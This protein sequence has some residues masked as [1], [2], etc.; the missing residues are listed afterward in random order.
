MT[1]LLVICGFIISIN[2]AL[3][4]LFKF[5]F[6]NH[7][8][9]S[10]AFEWP[11]VS[12]LVAARNEERHLRNCVQALLELDYPKEK[13]QILIGNDDSEDTTQEIIDQLLLQDSRITSIKIESDYKGLIAKSNVIAQL[14]KAAKGEFLAII[15]A[16]NTVSRLWLQGMVK[17]MLDGADL[18]SGYTVVRVNSWLHR[19]QAV[20]W[21]GTLFLM[22]VAA[23]FGFPVSALGNNMMLRKSTYESMGGFEALGPTKIE[24]L[25]MVIAFRKAGLKHVQIMDFACQATTEPMK[26]FWDLLLQRKRWLSGILKYN[27]FLSIILIFERLTILVVII[28]FMYAVLNQSQE[29]AWLGIA[30]LLMILLEFVKVYQVVFKLK[31]DL[32]PLSIVVDQILIALLNTF[33]LLSLMVSPKVIWKNRNK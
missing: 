33:A 6:K 19:M 30:M 2:A 21:I 15:D 7:D 20:D 16:D 29:V 5:N 10:E 31:G 13:I 14:A 26:S 18:V 24:D 11:F 1:V 4:L 12:I 27:P 25:K 17:P 23:D 22:K 8:Q 32:R 28:A 9:L 3:I